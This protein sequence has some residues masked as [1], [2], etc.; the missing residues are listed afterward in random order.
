MQ[1]VYLFLEKGWPV[2][3]WEKE[4]PQFMGRWPLI[5]KYSDHESFLAAYGEAARKAMEQPESTG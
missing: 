1:T 3:V 5:G 4:L 2:V